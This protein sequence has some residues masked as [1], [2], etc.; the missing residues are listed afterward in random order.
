MEKIYSFGTLWVFLLISNI[1]TSMAVTS[2]LTPTTDQRGYIRKETPSIGACEYGGRVP[3]KI[4]KVAPGMLSSQISDEDKNSIIDLVLTGE[5]NRTDFITLR[6][7][8]LLLE[9]LDISNATIV[10][11]GVNPVNAI[12]VNA[13]YHTATQTGKATLISV[14]LPNGATMISESAFNACSNLTSVT[15][16]AHLSIIGDYAFKSSGLKTITIPESITSLGRFSFATATLNTI[17]CERILPLE[18]VSD[19]FLGVN[20]E[21]CGLFVPTE[22]ASL[23]REA[24]YWGDFTRI[25]GTVGTPPV[26]T[27]ETN[28]W[29]SDPSYYDISWYI[30][31]ESATEYILST[32][33]ELAGFSLL[34]NGTGDAPGRPSGT[35]GQVDFTAKTVKLGADIDL[36]DHYWKPIGGP[37]NSFKG[38]FDGQ[39]YKVGGLY[40]DY[41]TPYTSTLGNAISGSA[42]GGL[43]NRANAVAFFGRVNTSSG[44]MIK[45]LT[46]SD[47]FISSHPSS[48][49]T[50]ALVAYSNGPLIIQNVIIENIAV[51]GG[52]FVSSFVGGITNA[53]LTLQ[54]CASLAAIELNYATVE[55]V[56][57]A[58]TD[59]VGGGLLAWSNGAPIIKNSYFAGMVRIQTEIGK[60]FSGT[61][62]AAIGNQASMNTGLLNVAS[63][64]VY[65]AQSG[66]L[67]A[68]GDSNP[69]NITTFGSYEDLEDMCS[70]NFVDLLNYTISDGK[71]T[72]VSGVNRGFP[73]LESSRT[74]IENI[75]RS[76][77]NL[78]IINNILLNDTGNPVTI[79]N[80]L[81]KLICKKER[82]IDLRHLPKGI[83]IA[84]SAN[85]EALKFLR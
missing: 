79:Y 64:A 46:L 1:T 47:G 14:I 7:E 72:L 27:Q 28:N 67:M 23:Y 8:F 12:P 80:T 18:L 78:K 36:R 76:K 85:G 61:I 68:F 43:A 10:A 49:Y 3:V 58:P 5:I 70:A 65:Y 77:G 9:T 37:T 25:N 51:L 50:A 11:E 75:I 31:H 63:Q 83:Y 6:D 69:E 62:L 4:L 66:D 55:E 45:N 34:M 35:A 29:W 74:R 59:A 52:T 32:P 22:S 60:V 21:I 44:T 38:I 16:S 84:K 2:I 19:P 26:G 15:L 82:D 39:G 20:K 56:P 48:L 24:Q 33:A 13:F 41:K 81:G 71:W 30:G 73:I 57:T 53:N 40:I 42:N 17:T 54:N